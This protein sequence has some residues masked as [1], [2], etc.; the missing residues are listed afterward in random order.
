MSRLVDPTICP[1]C[2]APLDPTATCTG[3]G[4]RIGGPLAARLWQAMTVADGLVE[5]L[6]GAPAAQVAA[7]VAVS[8]PPPAGAMPSPAPFAVRTTAPAR[9]RFSGASAPVVLLGLGALCLLVAAVVFVAVAWSSLGLTAKTTILLGLTG[10]L[11]W[12]ASAVTRRELRG[13]TETL[14]IVVAVMLVL[15]VL[16][17]HAADLLGL[18]AL[19]DRHLAGLVGGV[20]LVLGLVVGAWVS[21]LP[22]RQVAGLSGL[23]GFGALVLTVSEAWSAPHPGLAT[24]IA[25]PLLAALAWLVGRTIPVTSYAVAGVAVLTWLGLFTVGLHALTSATTDR[26]WWAD[27][28]GWT[29]LVAAGYAAALTVP[30]VPHAVRVTGAVAALVSLGLL[31]AGP[32]TSPTADLVTGALLLVA[33]A[34]ISALAP[35]VWSQAAGL[36]TAVGLLGYGAL[37]VLR[38]F[39]VSA[40]LPTHGPRGVAGLGRTAPALTDQPAPWTALLVAAVV[41]VA[42]AGLVRHLPAERRDT[43]WHALAAVAPA[44]IVS[45]LA[46][47]LLESSATITVVA[48][49]FVAAAALAGVGAVLFRREPV[50]L[51]AGALVA[52][53]AVLVALRVAAASHFLSSVVA[54]LVAVVLAAAYARVE[55]ELHD[56]VPVTAL[57]AAT[58]LLVGYAALEWPYVAHLSLDARAI[59]VAA[60]AALAGLAAVAVGRTPASRIAVEGAALAVGAVAAALPQH[61]QVVTVVLTIVGTAIAL[62]SVLNRDRASVSWL[63]VVVLGGASVLRLLLDVR[64]PEVATL[65]AAALLLGAGAWRLHREPTLSSFSALGSGLTLALLPSLVISLD[66]PVSLRGALVGAAGL[67]AL[68]VGVVRHW[69]APFA[70]GAITVGLLALRHLG[71]V[72]EALPRWI[73]LGLVGVALLAIGVTWEARRRDLAAAG[74]YLAA[75]H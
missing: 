6:R 22:L 41:L 2:R 3:C 59:V 46:E 69:A 28:S 75:L 10:L 14:W 24:S 63:A 26:A 13:A 52:A 43:A 1:D 5:Q 8:P 53:Y 45:G 60:V 25:I 62:V 38:P 33:L 7:T 55:R 66:E 20:L 68:A 48:G 47:Q 64:L 49:T 72:A 34:G 57:A 17:A 35:Q 71:P 27:F 9:H 51:A 36:L 58:T 32:F 42:A 30:R 11:G 73:S 40:S 65:P 16:A 21:E 50:A 18:S 31:A 74:T 67:I 44:T 12:A 15:D 56:G 23:A 70:A 37:L 19:P 39:A 29:L 54:T 4:L 61:T